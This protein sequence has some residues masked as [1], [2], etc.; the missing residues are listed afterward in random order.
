MSR[1]AVTNFIAR[2]EL[3]CAIVSRHVPARRYGG[4]TEDLRYTDGRNQLL[5][6]AGHELTSSGKYRQEVFG[7]LR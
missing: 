7:F 3:L 6:G 4:T 5:D 1:V 2:S